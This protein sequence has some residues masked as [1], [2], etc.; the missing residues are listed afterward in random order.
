MDALQ[1][2]HFTCRLKNFDVNK[3][4]LCEELSPLVTDAVSF[5]KKLC[6]ITNGVL[7]MESV[8]AT[9]QIQFSSLSHLQ[10]FVTL[11][12]VPLLQPKLKNEVVT[13]M[14]MMPIMELARRG[15]LTRNVT[16][17]WKKCQ[18]TR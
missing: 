18:I 4:N 12:L 7:R 14:I 6:A 8:E 1:R 15:K 3:S 5:C 13:V 10:I 9:R 17:F 16:V 2:Y 11:Y